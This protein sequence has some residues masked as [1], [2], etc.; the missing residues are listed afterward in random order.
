MEKICCHSCSGQGVQ[1]LFHDGAI[2]NVL[3]CPD[4]KGSG[5]V[6]PPSNF[7]RSVAARNGKAYGE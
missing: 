5:L 3:Q 2:V 6:W 7:L 1:V 4:C